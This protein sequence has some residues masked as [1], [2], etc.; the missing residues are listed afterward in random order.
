MTTLAATVVILMFSKLKRVIVGAPTHAAVGSFATHIDRIG[1]SIVDK[2]HKKIDGPKRFA[3]V[4][5]IHGFPLIEEVTA[6]ENVLRAST[7]DEGEDTNSDME[8]GELASITY[9]SLSYWLLRALRSW[10]VP[11]VEADDHRAIRRLQRE[12]D[13]SRSLKS[14]RGVATGHISW[15]AYQEDEP[16]S[17]EVIKN[18][19]MSLLWNAD[20]LCVPPFLAKETPYKDWKLSLANGIAVDGGTSI[21]RPV[22]QEIWG[23]T[24]LL[25]TLAGDHDDRK[26]SWFAFLEANEW[27]IFRSIGTK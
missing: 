19:M 6:F 15:A 11:S 10:A 21:S 5:V 2:I 3:H 24:L 16:G 14:L 8:E 9:L 13:E 25:C 4:L 17:E 22:L 26:D 1:K 18:L 27:P 20:I 7:D 12:I 23:N